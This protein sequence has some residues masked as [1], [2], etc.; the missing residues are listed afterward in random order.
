MKA[1]V[2]NP[3]TE[4]ISGVPL[5]ERLVRGLEEA[6]ISDVRVYGLD[7]AVGEA[8]HAV[9]ADGGETSDGGVLYVD[10]RHYVD[11]RIFE[12]V[13]DRQGTYLVVDDPRE[14]GGTP[15]PRGG[16]PVAVDGDAV[17]AVGRDGDKLWT[18]VARLDAVDETRTDAE[19]FLDEVAATDGLGWFNVAEIDTYVTKLRRDVPLH[20]YR[21]DDRESRRAAER[22]VLDAS[23]KSPADLVATY[24]HD[25]IEDRV[26][27]RLANRSITPNQITL[28]V[29][30]V[31]YLAT[32]L[33]ATGY[34][35]PASLL[36]FAVGLADGFDGKLARLTGMKTR[37]GAMEHSFDLLYEFS[38]IVA[39]GY[40][41]SRSAGARPL[42]LAAGIVTV[43]AFYRDLYDRFSDQTGYSVDVA[44]P[45]MER[46]QLVTGRRNVY[47]LHILAFVLL[48]Y[49][50][51][52]LYTIGAHA[53]LTATVYSV[54]SFVQ[55][56]R[57]D[58]E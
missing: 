53:V 20:W 37:V 42:L 32:A 10:G 2:V 41:L 49:P 35:L 38:W 45:F 39:L 34:L 6:G 3:S 50:L 40:Y 16:I 52:A 48:G 36:T 23:K 29:N 25:P 24:V 43:V 4:R 51:F 33:F 7:D 5:V 15:N 57:L 21:V 26:V 11:E 30:V 22:A 13:A 19:S 55:L 46:F 12:A 14:D 44:S 47:N 17:T 28:L 8:P 27:L 54:Q 9:S 58:N 1:V 56:R 18:G 31:A